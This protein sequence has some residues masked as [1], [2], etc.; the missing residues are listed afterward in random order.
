MQSMLR[1]CSV[2]LLTVM[3]LTG[4]RAAEPPAPTFA[5]WPQSLAD[6]RFRWA[7]EPGVDLGSGPAVP[8][9]AYLESYRIGQL[10]GDIGAAYPGFDRAV[11]QLPPDSDAPAQ[12]LSIRPSPDAEPFGPPGPF[13]GNEF[14]HILEITPIEGGYRAYVCDGLYKIFR[15]GKDEDEGKYV[16]VVGYRAR[17]GLGDVNGMKVWRVEFTDSPPATD[18][19]A[20]V[21]GQSGPNP[22]PTGDV[23]GPWRITGASDANWGTLVNRESTADERMDGARRIS[24]CSDLLPQWRTERDA[25]IRASLDAPPSPEPAAPGWPEAG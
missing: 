12:L 6:F 23:F 5:N 13:F 11:P 24:Q 19:P 14:F 4:C 8:L 25:N 22:A 2:M 21:T 1:W 15:D 17:T 20:M 9:R 10:T 16:S 18:A 7:A 3:G